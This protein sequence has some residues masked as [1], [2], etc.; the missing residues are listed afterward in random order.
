MGELQSY[1]DERQIPKGLKPGI[2]YVDQ[3]HNTILV[4]YNS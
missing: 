2:L 1:R 4:P 3:F